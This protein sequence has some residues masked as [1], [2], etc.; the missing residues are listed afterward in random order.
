[1]TVRLAISDD[2]PAILAIS[3]RA[4]AETAANF[5][6]EP[7]TLESWQ[8]SFAETRDRYPWYV[9]TDSETGTLTGFAKASPWKGRCAY[10]YTAEVTVYVVPAHH[11]RGIGRALY[12]RLFATL[13]G[14]GYRTVLAG[15]A[16]PNPAS[17]RLHESFG[18]THLGTLERVGWKFRAWHDVGMWQGLLGEAGDPPPDRLRSVEECDARLS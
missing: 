9:A 18:L 4:A 14:Q 11:R 13:R 7:E 2:L 10:D 6:V 1:M 15:I 3:N 16:L 8:R 12:E 5:A 17:V